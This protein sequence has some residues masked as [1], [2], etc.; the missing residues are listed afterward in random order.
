MGRAR[1]RKRERREFGSLDLPSNIPAS[2]RSRARIRKSD[3]RRK[4]SEALTDLVQPFVEED[5]SLEGFR[6][7][8]GIGAV[9]W[10][11]SLLEDPKLDHVSDLLK[12]QDDD[13]RAWF[14]AFVSD[15]VARKIKLFPKDDRFIAGWKVS[16]RPDGSYFVTAVGVG[17]E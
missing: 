4:V 12:D 10:N 7:L 2:I 6:G 11:L 8:V 9:A 3:R 15:L 13:Y 14:E 16:L 17:I 5:M 1:R